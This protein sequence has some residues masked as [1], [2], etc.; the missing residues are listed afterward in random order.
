MT[1][2]KRPVTP[3]SMAGGSEGIPFRAQEASEEGPSTCPAGTASA[4]GDRHLPALVWELQADNARLRQELAEALRAS[5]ELLAMMAHEIRVPLSTLLLQISL[6]LE[7]LRRAPQGLSQEQIESSLRSCERQARRIEALVAQL[8]EVSRLGR[9]QADLV[10]E[11]VDLCEVVRN[12]AERLAAE[13]DQMG[14]QLVLA[15]NQSACGTWD[16]A[17]VVQVVSTLIRS[18][19][20]HRAGQPIHIGVEQLGHAVRLVLSDG[21]EGLRSAE[22]SVPHNRTP[23]AGVNL[24]FPG[25]GLGLHLVRKIV[26]ALGG[27][28]WIAGRPGGGACLT[29]ELPRC[30]PPPG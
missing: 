10:F 11:E 21:A 18:V 26:G 8:L 2:P 19:A 29:V 22:D 17:R 24:A 3:T 13:L 5:D 16:R 14:C 30:R 12:V 1:G 15:A 9:E 27:S 20:R 7:M 23:R 28:V 4:E 25:L 6:S